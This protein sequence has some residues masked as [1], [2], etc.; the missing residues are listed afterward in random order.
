MAA[1]RLQE[2][3]V[4]MPVPTVGEEKACGDR[5]RQSFCQV[6][7]N[8]QSVLMEQTGHWPVEEQPEEFLR[9]LLDFLKRS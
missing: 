8:V 7:S 6:A 3:L 2:H 1:G 4:H 9:L 5:V